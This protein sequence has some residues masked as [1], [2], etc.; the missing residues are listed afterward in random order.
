[1]ITTSPLP[2]LNEASTSMPLLES[3]QKGSWQMLEGT[4]GDP[5]DGVQRMQRNAEGL[6]MGWNRS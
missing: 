1:M 2:S 3:E 5:A 4:L 6:T